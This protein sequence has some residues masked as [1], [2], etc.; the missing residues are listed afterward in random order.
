MDTQAYIESGIIESYVL[1]LASAEEAAEVAAFSM[2]YPEIKKAIDEFEALMEKFAF[3][4]AEVPGA[5]IKDKLMLKLEGEFKKEDESRAASV[6]PFSSGSTPDESVAPGSLLQ[7]KPVRMWQ[8]MAAAS[9][10]LF[11]LSAALNLYFYKNYRNTSDKYQALLLERT[12]LQANNDAYRTKLN[13][14]DESIR[15]MSDTATLQ[16][17]MRG[18]P[19]KENNFATVFWDTKTKDVYLLPNKL[20]QTQSDKQ[21]QLWAIVDGKPVNAGVIGDCD[22]LCKMHNIA[23]AQAFAITLEKRGGSPAPTLSAMY[24]MGGI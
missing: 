18:V 20:P 23:K 22:G 12:S 13:S 9:I 6:I 5:N 8:Y 24:V 4:N 3:D 7:P 15:L 16:I 17:K 1:G 14:L 11:I 10:V 21:F 2:Q 19:G